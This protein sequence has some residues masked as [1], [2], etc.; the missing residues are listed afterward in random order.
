MFERR[1]GRGEV[2]AVLASGEVIAEYPDD[3]PYPSVLL[4]ASVGSR[5]LHIVVG[6]DI[7]TGTCYIVTVYLPDPKLWNPDFRTRRTP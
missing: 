7:T 5:A 2:V 1:I 6:E 3:L 4:L